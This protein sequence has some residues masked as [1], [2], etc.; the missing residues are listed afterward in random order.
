MLQR[1][2]GAGAAVGFLV[3]VEEEDV[4]RTYGAEVLERRRESG[5]S[6]DSYESYVTHVR[7]HM[8]T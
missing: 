7:S 6:E 8:S 2:A 4:E 5:E 3:P 1:S